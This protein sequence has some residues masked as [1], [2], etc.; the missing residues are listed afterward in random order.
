MENFF[1]DLDQ[2]NRQR[3]RVFLL[4]RALFSSFA[5]LLISPPVL[6][7][8][9]SILIV[10]YAYLLYR[11]AYKK[12]GNKLLAINMIHGV[13]SSIQ[14]L[15][16]LHSDPNPMILAITLLNL[17]TDIYWWYLSYQLICFNRKINLLHSP[18]PEEFILLLES[19]RTTQSLD[20][21]NS[22]YFEAAKQWPKH[23]PLLLETYESQ[24]RALSS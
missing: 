13:A 8:I 7:F 5:L 6:S 17:S 24:R 16:V 2:K 9:T 22:R 1:T 14:Q 23:F 11:F 12:N 21:L 10:S 20:E 19:L 4:F 15:R 18:L 3:W